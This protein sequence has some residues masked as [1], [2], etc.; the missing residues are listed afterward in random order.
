MERKKRFSFHL[1][2]TPYS[3][4]IG[5]QQCAPESRLTGLSNGTKNRP[6][7]IL[8]IIPPQNVFP[9]SLAHPVARYQLNVAVQMYID[10][11]TG[12]HETA[13]TYTNHLHHSEYLLFAL[14][15]NKDKCTASYPKDVALNFE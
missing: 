3:T 9:Y 5:K 12:M 14:L 1:I 10:I 6:K 13:E 4:N 15:S 8:I 7:V 11:Y 2:N